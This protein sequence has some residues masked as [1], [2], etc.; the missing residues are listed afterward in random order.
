[1]AGANESPRNKLIA[2]MYLVFIAMLALNVSKEVL[3]GFG[4]IFKKIQSANERIKVGNESY[5]DKIATN[6]EE[7]EGKWINH[8][9]A[10]KEIKE[11]ADA[12]FNYIEDLKAR[13]TEKQRTGGDPN[14]DNYSQM[15]K[16]EA[17]DL[18]FFNPEGVSEEGEE[19]VNK[20]HD[21]KA[22]LIRVFASRFPQYKNLIEQRFQ[23]GDF[24]NN[25]INKD[26]QSQS[27]LSYNYEGFP[28]I[29][30]LAKFTILQ[31][32]IRLTETD[33]LNSLLGKELEANASV[34]EDNY[35]SILNTDKS[36]YY[37]GEIFNGSVIL[38]RKGGAQN[39]NDIDLLV[40]R[41]PISDE[42]Y[43]KIPGGIK[44]NLRTNN[45]GD[46]SITG[47]LIFL[48]DGVESKIPVEQTFTVIAKPNSAVISAD[49]MNV[50]YRGV[51]NP[52]TISIPGIPNSKIKANAPGLK[53]VR[54]SKYMMTPGRGQSIT[55]DARGELPDGSIV[56]S[57]SIFRIKDLPKP[58][59]KFRGKY[60]ET[61]IP[62]G[63]LARAIISADFGEDFDFELPLQVKSFR[64]Q[65]PGKAIIN[66]TG[67]KLSNE[68]LNAIRSLPSGSFFTVTGITVVAP[69]NPNLKFRK[70]SPVNII[71]KN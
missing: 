69:I 33:V 35:I 48:N 49:K 47:D 70:V 45:P 3:D 30:S 58:R 1:M 63:S 59:G 52:I 54:G 41:V 29:S 23:T 21:F 55:I 42:Q 26:G 19:F 66:C 4:Q 32:D 36:V 17:L 50:V 37:P 60:E 62:K 31:N 65:V 2:L 8:N 11:H 71:V 22:I 61:T 40:N 57:K 6:A 14:L 43:E 27:W 39:P 18:I 12:Y 5:Y 34:N 38:G 67:N 25:V 13:I 68:A 44:L 28:L 15:D 46:Y 9:K 56:S 7:K 51:E 64:V 16:G 53:Q 10:A 24:E 20:I